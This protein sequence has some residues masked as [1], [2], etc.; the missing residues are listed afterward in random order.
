MHKYGES[1]TTRIIELWW[2]LYRTSFPVCDLENFRPMDFCWHECTASSAPR[3]K[4]YKGGGRLPSHILAPHQ[5]RREWS[6]SC[7][8]CFTPEIELPVPI[9]QKGRWA[10]QP[11]C[12][13]LKRK[14]KLSRFRRIQCR[15]LGRPANIS[16]SIPTD[17][18]HRPPVVESD[19]I[20]LEHWRNEFSGGARVL[21]NTKRIHKLQEQIRW[22]RISVNFYY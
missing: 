7:N 20:L 17:V 14:K 22:T 19:L 12:T 6:D 21:V 11:I 16:V 10:P 5:D 1:K 9:T 2:Q 3:R 15:S 8:G 18:F 13:V 4:A